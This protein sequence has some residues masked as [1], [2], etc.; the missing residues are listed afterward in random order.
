MI[1]ATAG[2]NPAFSSASFRLEGLGI[3]RGQHFDR[4]ILVGN[5]VVRAGVERGFHHGLFARARLQDDLATV[6][7]LERQIGRAHV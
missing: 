3:G 1:S 5:D 6:L 2:L 4:T 7:E